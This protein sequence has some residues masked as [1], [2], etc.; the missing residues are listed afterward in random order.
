MK[1]RSIGYFR[2]FVTQDFPKFFRSGRVSFSYFIFL[3]HLNL[4]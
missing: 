3:L 2:G 1:P 4:L